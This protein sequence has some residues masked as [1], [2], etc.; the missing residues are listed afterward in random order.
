MSSA[1]SLENVKKSFGPTQIICGVSLEISI[2]ERHAI[3][4]PNGA[5]KIYPVSSD[6][7]PHPGLLGIHLSQG[8]TDLRAYALSDQPQGCVPELPG[9][10]YLSAALGLR[11]RPL[12]RPMVAG[13]RYS[14]WRG[15]DRLSDVRARTEQVIDEIELAD[16][17]AMQA[18]VL[19]YAEQRALEIGIAI[20]GGAEVIMLDEPS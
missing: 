6:Q 4:G 15:I 8:R 9:D 5:G 17:H 11:E 19:S 12:C 14:F 1:I 18:G 7:R 2:G 10:Q 20:A 3:I 16:R 13:Y